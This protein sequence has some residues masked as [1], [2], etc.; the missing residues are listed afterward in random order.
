MTW[1]NTTISTSNLDSGSDQPK[2]ARADLLATVQAVN[3]MISNGPDLGFVEITFD[4]SY[5]VYASNT[6]RRANASVAFT[7]GDTIVNKITDNGEIEFAPGVYLIDLPQ[8]KP[9]SAGDWV[10]SSNVGEFSFGGATQAYTT[11][12]TGLTL[13]SIQMETYTTVFY[14]NST[15]TANLNFLTSTAS[16]PLRNIRFTRMA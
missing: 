6:R 14:A 4:N 2:N 1:P 10:W 7:R 8:T 15:A 9:G 13:Y 5:K 12:G 16:T 3:Q 11:P